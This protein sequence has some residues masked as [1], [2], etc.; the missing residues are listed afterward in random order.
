MLCEN[1]CFNVLGEHVS[2]IIGP[3]DLL[4]LKL[5]DPEFGLDPEVGHRQMSDKA[6]SSSP[7]NANCRGR[8]RENGDGKGESKVGAQGLQSKGL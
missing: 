3:C 7:A 8:A 2:W 1:R 5:S 4:Q 6:E